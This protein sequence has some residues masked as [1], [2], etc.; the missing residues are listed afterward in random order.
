MIKDPEDFYDRKA[1]IKKIFSRI[2]SSRPQ[3]I[4][5]VGDRRIGKSSLLYHICNE[6]IRRIYLRNH[7]KYIFAFFDFQEKKN[8][9]VQEFFCI[10]AEKI[11]ETLSEKY[12]DSI[13]DFS[14]DSFL[15][16]I[17]TVIK[18]MNVILVFDEFDAITNNKNFNSE[19]FSFLRSIANSYNVA[20]IT[21]SKRDLQELCHT[22]EIKDSP[23]FNIFTRIPL[24]S[25]DEESALELIRVP[26]I[27]EGVPLEAYADFLL[28]LGGY[29][30][31]FV[32]IACSNLFEV[33]T[34]NQNRLDLDRVK[35]K[36]LEESEDHFRYM[37]YRLQENEKACLQAIIESKKLDQKGLFIAR[38]LEKKGILIGI[39]EYYRIFSI[40]FE[41]FIEDMA[42]NKVDI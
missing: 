22:H 19:F 12:A 35:K 27:K 39:G 4:S 37:W 41:Q 7:E 34:E 32:Q 30:P 28:N 29:H 11:A 17:K 42:E 25:F 8:M 15:K 20:Y 16:F 10:V 38:K 23:F 33:L 31:L 9:S 24:G 13:Q 3:S 14:Y 21:S 1:E 40:S 36:F 6:N 26:S 5:I 2:G 18:Y